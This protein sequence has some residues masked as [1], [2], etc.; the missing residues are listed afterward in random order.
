MN[1][2]DFQ[3]VK[4]RDR[5]LKVCA[6]EEWMVRWEW[7]QQYHKYNGPSDLIRWFE[8]GSK[9][10]HYFS[11]EQIR[12]FA[13]LSEVKNRKILREVSGGRSYSFQNVD[14]YNATDYLFQ[15]LYPVPSRMR[16]QRILDFGAGYGRQVNLWSQLQ[17]E[18]VYVGVD[19][20]ELPYCLQNFNYQQFD[21]ALRDYVDDPETFRIEES[22]GIYHLPTWRCDLLP[23]GFFDMVVCVQ[24]LQEINE[25]LVRYMIGVFERCLKPGGALY[26]RDHDL[27]WQPAHLLDLNQ[28][29]SERGFV[30]EFRPLAIDNHPSIQRGK[31]DVHGIPR[32]WR[33]KWAQ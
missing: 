6:V 18:L 1:A 27:A 26:I 14:E 22:P 11:D 16:V 28:Y 10:P 19:G 3:R 8:W 9:R 32:I 5:Q 25:E 31:P 24:V 15:N 13:N 2:D 17:K 12:L 7:A 29:L 21:L 4:D 20:I 30:L 23:S 33:K